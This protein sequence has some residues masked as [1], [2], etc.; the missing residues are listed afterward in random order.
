M[1]SMLIKILT[2]ARAFCLFMN[3]D[4]MVGGEFEKGLANL[5]SVTEVAGNQ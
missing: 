1:I 4:R 5:K 3:M 2:I